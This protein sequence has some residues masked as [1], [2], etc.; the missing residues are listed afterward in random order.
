MAF[1][2]S[3]KGIMV[4]VESHRKVLN[5]FLTVRGLRGSRF[6]RTHTSPSFH[7]LAAQ[8]Y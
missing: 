3:S 6:L 4:F 8:K 7:N 2:R 1:K 5:E